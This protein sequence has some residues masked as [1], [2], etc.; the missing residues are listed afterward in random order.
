M[1]AA[2]LISA[3]PSSR[4]RERPTRRLDDR[5][6]EEP[7]ALAKRRKLFRRRA[8]RLVLPLQSPQI[9]ERRPRGV[10]DHL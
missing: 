9:V 5:P 2:S 6:V 4:L 3:P 10:L 8:D 7:G 1:A